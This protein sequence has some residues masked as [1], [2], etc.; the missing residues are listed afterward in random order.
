MVLCFGLNNVSYRSVVLFVFEVLGCLLLQLL[1]VLM[2]EFIVIVF[3][4]SSPGSWAL[5]EHRRLFVARL[6][7]E[8]VGGK[9]AVGVLFLAEV[10]RRHFLNCYLGEHALPGLLLVV[11]ASGLHVLVTV[12]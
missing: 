12:M 11:A 2:V 9:D 5:V 8:R 7:R 4:H 6:F 1:L 3:G 10:L